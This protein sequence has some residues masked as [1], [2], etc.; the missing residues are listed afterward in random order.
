[1]VLG[2]LAG[3][4]DDEVGGQADVRAHRT[5]LADR[6]LV[7]ERGVAALHRREDAVGAVLHRQVQV[8]HQLRHARVDVDQALRELVG[9]AGG[10]ADALDARDLGDVLDQHCEVGDL[11]GLA[12]L[13]AVG[14]D[15]LAQQRDLLDAL[16]GQA[17]HLGQHFLERAAEL[18]AAGVGHDAVGAV[19]AAALHDRDEGRRALD[20][21][22]RQMV[23]LL[24]L[25]EA[26]VDLRA[27][28]ALAGLEHL[29]QAVQRLR[30]E[31]HVDIGRALDD[32]CAFLAGHAA[33]DADQHALLLQVLDAAEIAEDLLLRL[34][35]HRAGVEEDQV[36]LFRVVGRRV[37]LGGLH[38]VGHLVRVVFVHLA[39]EGADVDLLLRR[40][41]GGNGGFVVHDCKQIET[42][43]TGAAPG[44]A[45]QG[46]WKKSS[47]ER[48][49]GAARP[50]AGLRRCAGSRPGR[51]GRAGSA[52]LPRASAARSSRSRRPAGSRHRAAAPSRR[53]GLRRCSSPSAGGR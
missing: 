37:A 29:R 45:G 22:R 17:R 32:G 30:A 26:D 20:P 14:V 18:L 13:A 16:V 27:A 11:A 5:Q 34:L 35:A 36:G 50:Q 7:F 21:R 42:K 1:M 19:L 24:D 47:D 6:A 48:P 4:A 53:T 33:A 41:I 28:G 15:V 2:R 52:R 43:A 31:D 8:V 46:R 39:A 25:G 49:W 3:E 44:A 10:V 51:P 40:R 9:V 38:D 12:H 23:E